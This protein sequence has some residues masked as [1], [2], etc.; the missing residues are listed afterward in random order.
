MTSAVF[1]ISI[2]RNVLWAM[3]KVRFTVLGSGTSSGVPL[4][5]CSCAVCRSKNP[6]NHRL[7][8]SVHFQ[9]GAKSFLIDTST[10]LRQ[11]ALR[12]KLKRVDAVLFTH[13]H[14]DHVHGIDELRSYN[15][16]QK[17]SI[18]VYGNAW[19]CNELKV[20][21]SYIFQPG[22]VEGGGIPQLLLNELPDTD[23]PF[24]ADG[25]RIQ[26][27]PVSHGSKPCLGYRIG[28]VAYVTDC[29][30]ISPKSF[31]HLRGLD[32]LVLDCV[33]LAAHRTHLNLESALEVVS[34]VDAKKVFLTHL[35]HDFDY[36]KANRKLPRG[37]KLA[38]DGLKLEGAYDDRRRT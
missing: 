27:I 14:A 11:Q 18:P 20:K 6:K 37:V 10:D 8:A 34:K 29:S 35:G 36:D 15:F 22:P 32:V 1:D 31:E 17:G 26:P 25:I 7:R 23:T 9:V 12:A 21:F 16:I 2:S 28:S 5:G 4:I 13:P 30:Y 33:R 3:A 19:T 24:W 38:F